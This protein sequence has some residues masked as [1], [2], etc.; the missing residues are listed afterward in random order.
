MY[1]VLTWNRVLLILIEDFLVSSHYLQARRAVGIALRSCLVLAWY[2]VLILDRA[3]SII[4][5]VFH[6]FSYSL[7]ENS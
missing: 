5:E 3:L 2:P 1:A 4:T 6:C 7:N